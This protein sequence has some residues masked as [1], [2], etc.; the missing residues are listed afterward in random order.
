MD[1]PRT[2]LRTNLEVNL[3]KMPVPG[4]RTWLLP[5]EREGEAEGSLYAEACWS[6]VALC[7]PA[8]KVLLLV[9]P[10]EKLVRSAIEEMFM[11]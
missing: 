6:R 1:G 5:W 8:W 10:L 3:L 9:T 7:W 11:F 4:R 2:H